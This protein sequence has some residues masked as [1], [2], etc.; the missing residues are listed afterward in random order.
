MP[1][2]GAEKI[3]TQIKYRLL[4]VFGLAALLSWPSE[5]V[6]YAI[7]GLRLVRN[8]QATRV[9]IKADGAMNFQV[10][11]AGPQAVVLHLPGSSLAA[12]IPETTADPLISRI[13]T[14]PSR[15]AWR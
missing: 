10:E 13:E 4:M 1:G 6:A 15:A 2:Q 7:T 9:V 12:K 14:N 3:S 8:H 11:L 5:A